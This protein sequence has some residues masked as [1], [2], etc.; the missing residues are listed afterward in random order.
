[1][2]LHQEN[3]TY[4]SELYSVSREAMGT[5]Q[6]VAIR[7]QLG[8]KDTDFSG[9]VRWYAALGESTAK[10]EPEPPL[11]RGS[12]LKYRESVLLGVCR[13][14]RVDGAR[15]LWS[16]RRSCRY[17]ELEYQTASLPVRTVGRI[18]RC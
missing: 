18:G 13:N 3:H 9:S 4:H 1:M 6:A 12:W 10:P 7:S 15:S 14:W 5:T 2:T 8:R 17:A 16:S 11:H